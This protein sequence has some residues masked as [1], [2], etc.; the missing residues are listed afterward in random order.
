MLFNEYIP[1]VRYIGLVPA[2]AT[3][4]GGFKAVGKTTNVTLDLLQQV[5]SYENAAA[6][7]VELEVVPVEFADEI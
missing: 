5:K 3:C 4:T 6:I 2:R 1:V 7:G